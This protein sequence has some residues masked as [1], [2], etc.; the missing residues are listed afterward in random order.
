M[1]WRLDSGLQLQ[2]MP[3]EE[4]GLGTWERCAEYIPITAAGSEKIRVATE[5]DEWHPSIRGKEPSLSSISS[6]GEEKIIEAET[7]CILSEA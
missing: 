2:R 5:W 6:K 1:Y 7:Y 3:F 4:A